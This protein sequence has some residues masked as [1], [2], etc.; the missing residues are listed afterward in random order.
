[1]NTLSLSLSHTC[2]H[3]FHNFSSPFCVLCKHSLQQLASCSYPPTYLSTSCPTIPTQ[4]LIMFSVS[5][6][7]LDSKCHPVLCQG[8]LGFVQQ[9]RTEKIIGRTVVPGK[10]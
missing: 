10:L 4:P 2:T 7:Q 1:M 8:G 5:K 9:E 3:N 6:R